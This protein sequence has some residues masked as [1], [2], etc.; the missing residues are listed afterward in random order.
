MI[1][2]AALPLAL[3]PGAE[4][5]ANIGFGSGLTTHTLLGSPRVKRLDSIEIERMMIEGAR[6]FA[7]NNQRAYSDPRSHIHIE[8]AK[9][10]F[11][12][13]AQ[14]YDVI[15]SEPS[16]P[17]VSGV[18]TLFS[19]EWYAQVK[20]YL[21]DDGLLVQ[22]VQA[23]EINVG[24]LSTIFQALG[25]NFGDY[26]VYRT[27]ADLL[28]VA[29]PGR[30]LPALSAGVFDMSGVAQDLRRIG[31]QDLA[32]LQSLRVG[33]RRALEPLFAQTGFPPNSDFF[34]I[35]DQRAP[36]ARYKAENSEELPRIRDGLV[37]VL[38]VLDGEWLTP[39]SRIQNV[40][41][42]HPARVDSVLVGAEAIG[43]F[44]TGASDRARA[45]PL[46]V[47]AAALLAHGYLDNCAGASTEWL[48]AMT[49][50]V[51]VASPYLTQPEA[52][53][54]FEKARASRCY[55]SLDENGKHHIALLEAIGTRNP[56]G[57]YAEGEFL[58]RNVPASRE[59]ERG[60][61]FLAALT[62]AVAAGRLPEAR[63]LYD[64]YF[65]TL[66]QS[67]RDSLAVNLLLA[68]VKW[69]GRATR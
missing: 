10:Y 65:V 69:A 12:S 35:L 2:A 55:R 8:D 48:D 62:G 36:R 66:T 4:Y 45:L 57:M 37:P 42:N 22:W 67:Q 34:P 23:Y 41:P 33:G 51:R 61:Y 13:N 25:R 46:Q 11:A 17:W 16:N 21:K 47:R 38:G 30:Q 20:R 6:L 52:G 14:R 3:K 58:L 19:D 44:L 50:V 32:D 31:F 9:T 15:V 64:R 40:S 49:E 68:H 26:T 1:L 5:V 29:T 39:L 54:I 63:A 60:T 59:M 56:A 7:P 43:V 18:A 53:V 24:L 27:G 28:V